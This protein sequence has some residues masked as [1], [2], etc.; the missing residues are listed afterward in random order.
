MSP[1]ALW[2]EYSR[3]FTPWK[4]V[5]YLTSRCSVASFFQMDTMELHFSVAC[6][7]RTDQC[8]DREQREG[9]THVLIRP[10]SFSGPL[11]IIYKSITSSWKIPFSQNTWPHLEWEVRQHMIQIPPSAEITSSISYNSHH[12][13]S[14]NPRSD[15][16]CPVCVAF[17]PFVTHT[18][19]ACCRHGSCSLSAHWKILQLPEH[20]FVLREIL[21]L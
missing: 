21:M 18:H 16:L 20:F 11:Q 13:H 14:R 12:F 8:A 2:V 7:K 15:P 4:D 17:L 6:T 5:V 19:D 9:L 10:L 3:R 1:A